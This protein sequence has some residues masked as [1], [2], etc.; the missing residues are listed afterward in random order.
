MR[1]RTK[2]GENREHRCPCSVCAREENKSSCLCAAKKGKRSKGKKQ[3]KAAL[4]QQKPRKDVILGELASCLAQ[5][6]P[7]GKRGQS[8]TAREEEEHRG[9]GLHSVFIGVIFSNS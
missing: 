1:S 9:R 3:Q 5:L 7:R 4:R 2:G 8:A 6:E